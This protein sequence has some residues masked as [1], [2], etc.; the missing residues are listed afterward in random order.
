MRAR[1]LAGDRDH[2]DGTASLRAMRSPARVR[3]NTPEGLAMGSSRA[4]TIARKSRA[5]CSPGRVADRRRVRLEGEAGLPERPD[6]LQAVVLVRRRRHRQPGVVGEQSSGRGRC[7][8]RRTRRR[9]G[10]RDRAPTFDVARHAVSHAA[11]TLQRRATSLQ[12]SLDRRLAGLEHCSPLPRCRSRVRRGAEPLRPAEAA[13]V[14]VRQ[15]TRARSP[16]VW[17]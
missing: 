4:A 7:R 10:G 12:R 9:S 14:A 16:P 1:N 6:R 17:L 2:P 13:C 11:R 5:D 15:R 3:T 8:R